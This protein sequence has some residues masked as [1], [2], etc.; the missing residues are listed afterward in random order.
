ME[1]LL[2]ALTIYMAGVI[3]Y[4]AFLIIRV[5]SMISQQT[6][7]NFVYW[8]TFGTALGWPVVIPFL[9]VKHWFSNR[10]KEKY[11]TTEVQDP[12]S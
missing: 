7:Y 5:L 12:E 4:C 6:H 11:E 2:V 8:K 9:N 1:L 10:M 3:F